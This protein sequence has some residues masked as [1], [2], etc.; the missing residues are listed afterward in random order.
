MK[1]C[2][3]GGVTSLVK[4]HT[5]RSRAASVMLTSA[6]ARLPS[7]VLPRGV[8]HE[9]SVSDQPVG[10]SSRA[11]QVSPAAR[12]NS[13]VLADSWLFSVSE[14]WPPS[15]KLRLP[16]KLN[17]LA[18][19]TL[20]PLADDDPAA[21]G[22]RRHVVGVAEHMLA[23]RWEGDPLDVVAVEVVDRAAQRAE[24]VLA[25][26]DLV[27]DRV[28]GRAA[29]EPQRVARRGPLELILC[30]LDGHRALDRLLGVGPRGIEEL[31]LRERDDVRVVR[32]GDDRERAPRACDFA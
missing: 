24:A 27:Q 29:L 31:S 8:T 6:A 19:S 13:D 4:V 3:S 12:K 21:G 32:I 10:T 5:T 22:R 1:S 26:V 16:S 15:L 25:G 7:Q 17:D 18:R 2:P 11:V 14:N 23:A 9:I 20:N 30:Q 28:R